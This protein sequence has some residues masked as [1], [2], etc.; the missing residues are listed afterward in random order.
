MFC[1]N[2]R[3][4]WNPLFW[5]KISYGYQLGLTCPL[6]HLK[7]VFC[8]VDLS[9]SVSGVLK[10]PTIIVLWLISPFIL[11]NICLMYW[12]AP[13]LGS[14]MFITVISSYRIDPFLIMCVLLCLSSCSLLQSLFY[15][16]WVLPLLRSF[17]L[18]WHEISFSSPSLSVLMYP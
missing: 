1:V 11:V 2:L 13:L 6:Y 16:I 14:Y 5:G 15:L 17:G 3:K 8:L 10:S 7:V 18:H 12:G 9:I 4:R